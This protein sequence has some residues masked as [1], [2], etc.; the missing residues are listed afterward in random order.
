MFGQFHP[1]LWGGGARCL[2][3]EKNTWY[4]GRK[5]SEPKKN[6]PEPQA[7]L[8]YNLFHSKHSN[9]KLIVHL[10]LHINR[11]IEIILNTMERLPTNI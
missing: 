8:T 9:V 6:V 5:V 2:D 1:I 10:H 4:L 11:E 7:G 3:K